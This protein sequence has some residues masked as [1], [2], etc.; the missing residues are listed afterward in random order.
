MLIGFL[1]ELWALQ[2]QEPHIP[3][4]LTPVHPEWRN[5]RLVGK[6][7]LW[8]GV[9]TQHVS[10]TGIVYFLP[11][12]EEGGRRKGQAQG[13]F[14]LLL[15]CSVQSVSHVRLFAIPWTTTHQ[16]SLS[17]TNSWSLPKLVAIE[18]WCHPTISSS[19]VPFSS[20]PQSFPA[21][22]SFQMS[23]PFASGGQSIEVLAST[24]VLPMDT[25]DWSPLGW[26]GWISMQYKGLSRVRLGQKNDDP[27]RLCGDLW[28]I[29]STKYYPA[30]TKEFYCQFHLRFILQSP[31]PQAQ[32]NN[33]WIITFPRTGH[34]P[35]DLALLTDYIS[36]EGRDWVLKV[37]A[38][39]V[40]SHFP[41]LVG[42]L[43]KHMRT[44][45]GIWSQALPLFPFKLFFGCN[46]Q[47]NFAS[48]IWSDSV[49]STRW[50]WNLGAHDSKSVLSM[51]K[52]CKTYM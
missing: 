36:A 52:P 30:K 12:Y 8:E 14:I 17:I 5:E 27:K 21:S 13:P 16:A 24:S 46:K 32:D 22:G 34:L 41:A 33:S 45:L 18:L 47:C 11:W 1:P 39:A 10:R 37:F 43:S 25:Q 48:I 4:A 2:E 38:E 19:V 20:C 3:V 42:E 9:T 15:T 28:F 26:T 50:G 44:F 7:K 40:L 49:R 35:R 51:V 23:Q 29:Y 31:Q 6:H